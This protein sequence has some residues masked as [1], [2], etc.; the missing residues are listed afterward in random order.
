MFSGKQEH[1]W[2]GQLDFG[3]WFAEVCGGDA[4]PYHNIDVTKLIKEDLLSFIIQCAK[5]TT[6]E[7]YNPSAEFKIAAMSIQNTPPDMSP[8]L[9]LAGLPQTIND[10][11][12]WGANILKVCVEA[13]EDDSNEVV[14]NATT[15][16]V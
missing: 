15:G 3:T 11:N 2:L 8:A 13:A 5:R 6:R 7:N 9:I 10:S 4:L 16:G 12:S 14:L 1:K